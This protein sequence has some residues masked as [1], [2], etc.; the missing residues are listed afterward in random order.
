MTLHILIS[1][2]VNFLCGWWISYWT[3]K[4][5]A[6]S[7]AGASPFPIAI[8]VQSMAKQMHTCLLSRQGVRISEFCGLRLQ[9][10]RCC[11]QTWAWA[12]LPLAWVIFFQMVIVI[13]FVRVQEKGWTMRLKCSIPLLL[14][15]HQCPS[16]YLPRECHPIGRR[17][18]HWPHL[19]FHLL[20][21][22]GL[23]GLK[24][25]GLKFQ[26]HC[27]HRWRC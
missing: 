12:S 25:L 9:G 2:V 15:S 26:V 7:V 24:L 10:S 16:L 27:P 20:I 4:G 3:F 8:T 17:E 19:A 13:V 21:K 14:G 18:V 1:A 5:L 11:S 6:L 23:Q 22:K